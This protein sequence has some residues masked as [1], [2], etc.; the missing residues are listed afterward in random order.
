MGAALSESAE[1]T[2]ALGRQDISMQ[3]VTKAKESLAISHR[4]MGAAM[5]SVSHGVQLLIRASANLTTA[6]RSEVI[7]KS[8]LDD[9][10]KE[11]LLHVPMHS[12]LL[13]G[14]LVPLAATRHQAIA[15]FDLK[16]KYPARKGPSSASRGVGNQRRGA[17][18]G[19]N[20]RGYY[21]GGS[22]GR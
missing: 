14:G 20:N 4:T 9:T 17:S 8:V 22:R 11:S 18:R 12:P 3:V 6:M 5:Q 2:L 19:G 10:V 15:S 13:F 21:R 7:S 16:R 1:A